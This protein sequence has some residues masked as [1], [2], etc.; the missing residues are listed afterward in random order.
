[1]SNGIKQMTLLDYCKNGYNQAEDNITYIIDKNM[2]GKTLFNDPESN[3][4]ANGIIAKDYF[5]VFSDEPET[6]FKQNDLLPGL[7]LIVPSEIKDGVNVGANNIRLVYH[8]G[9]QDIKE[10]EKYYSRWID[11][12]SNGQGSAPSSIL[13]SAGSGLLLIEKGN[14]K[15]FAIKNNGILT[16]MIKNEQITDEKIKEVNISKLVQTP[17]DTLVLNCNG[18]SNNF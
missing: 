5:I 1:M 4:Y 2:F 15:E 11:L 6:I 10:E 8:N 9:L 12:M 16:A 7:Y 17:G 3:E 18:S 13:Y 14:T